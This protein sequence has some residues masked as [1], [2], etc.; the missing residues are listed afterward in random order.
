VQQIESLAPFGHGNARPMLCTSGVS[1]S[2]PPKRIGATG[3][4]LSLRLEQ[5]GVRMRAV[6]FGGAEWEEGLA[7]T[8]GPLAVAF[9]PMINHYRGRHTVEMRLADWRPQNG[10]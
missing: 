2:E 7:A 9:Q 4:H 10:R 1:L 3:Q 6:A 8:T 5:H